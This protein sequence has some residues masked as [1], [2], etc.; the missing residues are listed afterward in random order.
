MNKV[1][2]PAFV[3]ALI[4]SVSFAADAVLPGA[5]LSA[6]NAPT[7]VPTAFNPAVIPTPIPQASTSAA[8]ATNTNPAAARVPVITASPVAAT[9]LAVS[10]ALVLPAAAPPASTIPLVASP[11]ATAPAEA[12]AENPPATAPVTTTPNGPI[13]EGE[14]AWIKTDRPKEKWV[15]QI[16]GLVPIPISS[17]AS[18]VLCV[19]YGGELMAGYPIT[20]QIIFGLETGYYYLP[21][22]SVKVDFGE[23]T[24]AAKNHIPVELVGQYHFDVGDP[25]VKPYFTWGLGMSLDF[26]SG[27]FVQ[28][29]NGVATSYPTNNSVSTNLEVDP[30]LGVTFSAGKN[31]DVFFQAKLAVEFG[32]VTYIF[33]PLQVG[34]NLPI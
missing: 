7:A 4:A 28:V 1:L 15:V 23:V 22:N 18:N 11:V 30:G 19:G 26:A 29:V 8:G 2:F 25:S 12:P 13:P 34:L 20:P 33:L 17:E 3:L 14:V 21:G 5:T 9:P 10:P 32:Y 24:Y 16:S 27:A 31:M 6:I